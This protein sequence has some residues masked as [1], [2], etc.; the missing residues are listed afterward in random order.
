MREHLRLAP[1]GRE[2]Q[3]F[4]HFR[5]ELDV[6]A[7]ER[8]GARFV[9]PARVPLTTAARKVLSRANLLLSPDAP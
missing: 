4:S 3:V 5:L 7:A 1:A 2:T 6:L 8:A 9:D